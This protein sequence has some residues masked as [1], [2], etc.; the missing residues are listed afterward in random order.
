LRITNNRENFSKNLSNDGIGNEVY[1]P[2]PVHKLPSFNSPLDLPNT[3]RATKEVLSIP[4]HPSL[5]KIQLDR[6]VRVFNINF[7]KDSSS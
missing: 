1:Y 6:I 4:V 5:N 2:K 3:E 7:K